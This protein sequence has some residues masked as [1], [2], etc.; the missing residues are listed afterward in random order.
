MTLIFHSVMFM[1]LF[2]DDDVWKR[3]RDDVIDWL[4]QEKI[5]GDIIK[6]INSHDN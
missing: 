2:A 4:L 1:N 3:E 6:L 5:R